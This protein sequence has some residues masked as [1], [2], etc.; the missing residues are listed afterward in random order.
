ME[1]MQMRKRR[2]LILLLICALYVSSL[3]GCSFAGKAG[4]LTVS[5]FAF[6]TT[7]T[8]SV[9]E[10]GDQ[11]L[12]DSCIDLCNDYEKIFS[13][14]RK[15]SELYA[16][17]AIS[18]AYGKI[19]EEMDEQNISGTGRLKQADQKLREYCETSD[20]QAVKDM[21]YLL[22]MDG[23]LS[24]QVSEEM[25]ELIEKGLD[26]GSQTKGAFDI[27]IYPVKRLWTFDQESHD[28]PEK[29]AV[30][31]ALKLVDYE[32][33]H[34]DHGKLIFELP[35]AQIDLGGIAKGYIADRLK[36]YL[37]DGGVYSGL[38]NLGG[39]ILCIGK[40]RDGSKFRIG[41]QQPFADRTD[42]IATLQISNA[43]IVSSGIYE[44]YFKKNGVI[45]HHILDTTT[46]YPLQNGL[47]GVSVVAA[48][49]VDAD[50]LSTSLFAMGLEEG[51]AWINRKAG[52]EAVFIT[53]DEKLH[54]SSNFKALLDQEGTP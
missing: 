31:E 21:S 22:D 30:R 12:L 14:T 39:N 5:G 50:A 17:D 2:G 27:S 28:V 15:D 16:I 49:S 38:I 46:G 3:S 25:Q 6:D 23:R 43:S 36:E 44:R 33:I 26:Y 32:K 40:K 9:Y 20:S 48:E 24:F 53:Q 42:T 45:Y 7:Y 37:V 10:G 51:L 19:K 52:I 34:M 1:K 47:L 54:Y 18:Q 29:S 11:E 4:N 35:G 13:A 8:I 41:V